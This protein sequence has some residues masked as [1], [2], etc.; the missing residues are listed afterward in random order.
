LN[1]KRRSG[2]RVLSNARDVIC[3]ENENVA[4]M[5][6]NEVV[7]KFINKD[8]IACVHCASRNN[9][10]ATIKPAGENAEIVSER[11]GWRIDQEI[12]V[13]A[14]QSRKGEEEENF[15]WFEFKNLIILTRDNV[16][17]IATENNELADLPQNIRR[18]R[19]AGITNDSV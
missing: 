14:N 8:L 2:F 10:A 5:R 1:V 3:P 11:L 15:F 17:V 13:T 16:D 12:L 7:A 9:V 6:F 19:R 4:A 18:W